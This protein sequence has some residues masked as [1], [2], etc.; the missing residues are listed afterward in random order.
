VPWSIAFEDPIVLPD[1]RQLLTLKDAADYVTEL[2]KE[3]SDLAH[4]QVVVEALLLCSRDGPPMLARI[5]FM[6]ALDRNVVI[7]FNS[8]AE[9]HHWRKRK[10]KRDE[11]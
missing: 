10:L 5:A 11:P 6:K 2:P 3:Q 9:K 4:W 8:D 1:G 7:P